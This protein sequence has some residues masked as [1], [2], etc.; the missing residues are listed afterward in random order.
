M[1]WGKGKGGKLRQWGIRERGGIRRTKKK[2]DATARKPIRRWNTK[3]GITD[4]QEREAR[5]DEVD[6]S[7]LLTF[8]TFRHW[9]FYGA[10]EIE[11]KKKAAPGIDTNVRGSNNRKRSPF[12]FRGE[13]ND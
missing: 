6:H 13:G 12:A 7:G 10:R 2:E 11:R 1:K 4:P 3:C 9:A 5:G 8:P